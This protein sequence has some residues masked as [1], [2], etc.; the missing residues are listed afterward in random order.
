MGVGEFGG[1]PDRLCIGYKERG[2]RRGEL[3]KKRLRSL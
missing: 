1:V 2:R 3:G